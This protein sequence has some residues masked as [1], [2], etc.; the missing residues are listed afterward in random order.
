MIFHH[1][2]GDKSE[3]AKERKKQKAIKLEYLKLV[4]RESDRARQAKEGSQRARCIG[5]RF[6]GTALADT[7]ACVLLAKL[8]EMERR[9]E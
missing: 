5:D 4:K 1:E 6:S 8:A 9:G 3:R 2:R 7:C